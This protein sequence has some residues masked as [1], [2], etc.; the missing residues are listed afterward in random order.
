MGDAMN[1]NKYFMAVMCVLL[2]SSS[3]IVADP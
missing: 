1:R 3:M 2:I